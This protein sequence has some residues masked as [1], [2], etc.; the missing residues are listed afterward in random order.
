MQRVRMRRSEGGGGVFI[1]D[2]EDLVLGVL[3]HPALDHDTHPGEIYTASL[4]SR[5]KGRM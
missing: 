3:P 5:E 1:R 4:G 2:L